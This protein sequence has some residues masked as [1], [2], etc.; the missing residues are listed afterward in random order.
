MAYGNQRHHPLKWPAAV[1]VSLV[2]LFAGIFLLPAHWIHLFYSPL[3]YLATQRKEPLA[4]WLRILPPPELEIIPEISVPQKNQ[5]APTKVSPPVDDPA[6]WT[7]AWQVKTNTGK[8]VIQSPAFRD[9][10]ILILEM[11]DVG[12]D[13]TRKALPD[14]LLNHRLMLLR[15]EDRFDFEELKPYLSALGRA[16]ARADIHSR[17]AAMYDEHL[18]STIMVPD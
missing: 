14:S 8:N 9:S 11:L 4:T 18:G 7:A 6:W 2:C 1:A 17:K 12:M 10:V 5:E 16:R 15:V 3:E 13:F